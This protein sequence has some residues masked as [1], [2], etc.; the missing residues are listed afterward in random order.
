[1]FLSFFSRFFLKLWSSKSWSES[2]DGWR[3]NYKVSF[4]ILTW[5]PNF[6][7]KV[8]TTTRDKIKFDNKLKF[9]WTMSVANHNILGGYD[10]R[11]NHSVDFQEDKLQ[12]I[13]GKL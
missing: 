10:T 9:V 12:T 4:L 2:K 3:V 7:R 5:K 11:K 1:M 6:H 8:A 13:F